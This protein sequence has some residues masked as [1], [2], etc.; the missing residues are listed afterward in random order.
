MSKAEEL[1][2]PACATNWK[3]DQCTC[4]LR[5]IKDGE[6]DLAQTHMQQNCISDG[7][8]TVFR[9]IPPVILDEIKR[10]YLAALY[11]AYEE[12][13][14]LMQLTPDEALDAWNSRG[15]E[16]DDDVTDDDTL[17]A[18]DG[19]RAAS[20]NTLDAVFRATRIK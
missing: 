20:L 19:G 15:A 11:E 13:A 6:L 5:C 10:D 18:D 9:A 4:C 12:R 14:Y 17:G 16:K 3:I 2:C 7:K 1:T 8:A